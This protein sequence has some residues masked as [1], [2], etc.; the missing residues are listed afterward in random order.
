[1]SEPARATTVQRLALLA[2]VAVGFALRA[3]DLDYGMPGILHPDELS[4]A[5]PAV[6]IADI[7]KLDLDPDFFNYPSLVI[8]VLAGVV[9]LANT[10]GGGTATL[11][12][13]QV[14]DAVLLG[15][16]VTLLFGVATIVVVYQLGRRLAGPRVGLLAALLLAVT[17]FHALDSHYLNVDIPL[18]FWCALGAFFLHGWWQDDRLRDLVL[19]AASIGFAGASKYNGLVLLGALAVLIVVPF[20]RRMEA[21]PALR[22]AALGGAACGAAFLLAAP[23][24]LLRFDDFLA[25]VRFEGAHVSTGHWAWDVNTGRLLH[26]RVLYQLTIGLPFV[27]G[28][29]L[30]LL[31]L[32]G[33]GALALRRAREWL[34]LAVVVGLLFLPVGISRVVFP[35]YLLPLAPFLV[36]VAAYGGAALFEGKR[37]TRMVGGVLLTASA[38]Y[39]SAVTVTMVGAL[40]PQSE[41]QASVWIANNVERNSEIGVAAVAPPSTFDMRNYRYI[42]F[43]PTHARG[44]LPPWLVVSSWYSRALER[45]PQVAPGEARFIESLDGPGSPY[46]RVIGFEARY[47]TEELYGLLD[48][49][50]ANQFESPDMTIYRRR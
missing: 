11:P 17:P 2:I 39:T 46:E 28:F 15:R 3:Y 16:W 1:M 25:A 41:E 7:S 19:G 45:A 8:Y 36:L 14:L 13:Q 31:T 20:R 23:Y 5:H 27:L 48:P 49:A 9:L 42:A 30:Y 37:P 29:A 12:D 24:T 21:G 40:S 4:L 35:R 44:R 18:T 22:A 50:L 34:P 6:R 26:Q 33:A 32:G 47:F 43:E 10:L 38:L